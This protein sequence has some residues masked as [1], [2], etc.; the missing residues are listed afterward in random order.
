MASIAKETGMDGS[1]NVNLK[2]EAPFDPLT[3]LGLEAGVLARFVYFCACTEDRKTEKM[4]TV[5][6]ACFSVFEGSADRRRVELMEALSTLQARTLSGALAQL[7]AAYHFLLEIKDEPELENH[8]KEGFC[9]RI[10]TI[11]YSVAHVLENATGRDLRDF[12]GGY[13]LQPHLDPF[14]GAP[15]ASATLERLSVDAANTEM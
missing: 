7:V 11:L 15:I 14:R 4:H 13:L 12:T 2:S 10:E 8:K 3:E 6:G 9:K 1:V 5:E